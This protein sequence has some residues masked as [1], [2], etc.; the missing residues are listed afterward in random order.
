MKT[1]CEI[2][3]DIWGQQSLLAPHNGKTGTG[4]GGEEP[5]IG[6]Q[7]RGL[8]SLKVWRLWVSYNSRYR[9]LNIP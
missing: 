6:R 2:P 5:D 9:A 1:I 3:K 4:N 7:R 8:Q